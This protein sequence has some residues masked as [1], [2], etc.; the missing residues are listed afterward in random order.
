MSDGE[1]RTPY[2]H[3]RGAYSCAAVQHEAWRAPSPDDLDV[4]PENTVGVPGAEGFHR[5]FLCGKPA[6]EVRC[7]VPTPRTISN[8]IVGKDAT[9]ETVAVTLEHVGDPWNIGGVDSNSEN[10][11][12][13]T[14][15]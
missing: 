1:Q 4:F 11:H 6:G 12:D 9:K 8:F 2:V 15:A 14:S 7:G 3:G 13:R 10:I 5:R